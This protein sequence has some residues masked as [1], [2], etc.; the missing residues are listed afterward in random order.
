MQTK[1]TP[2]T[3]NIIDLKDFQIKGS[4]VFTGRDRGEK[5]KNESKFMNLINQS[6]TVTVIIPDDVY[7]LNPSFLEEFISD[8]VIHL[9]SEKKFLEK[10]Q[11][12]S[13]DKYFDIIAE[14]SSA[15]GRVL[16]ENNALSKK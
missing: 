9:G 1:N 12:Q 6:E 7:S 11:F 13:S 2:N 8:A 4:Q 15:I 5:V 14:L 3:E 16:R 10:V